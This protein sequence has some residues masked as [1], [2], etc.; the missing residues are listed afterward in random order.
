[1]KIQCD[2]CEK[3]EAS[4]F[5]SAD[6]ASLCYA[7]DYTI[8]HANKLASKHKRFSLHKPTSKYTPLCDICQERRAYIFCREDRAIFCTEC[9]LPIH[10]ANENT[11][12]HNRFLLTGVKVGAGCS[13]NPTLLCSNGTATEIELRN[14]CS[15]ANMSSDTGSVSTSSISEYLT[16]TIPGYCMEDLLDAPNGF[17]Y[18]DYEYHI[19]FQDQDLFQ[20]NMCSFPFA[21]CSPQ[22]QV[23]SS[24][25]STWNVPQ[26]DYLVGVKELPKAQAVEGYYNGY[27]LPSVTPPLIKKSKRSR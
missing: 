17:F 12:K 8:H 19:K 4:V 21:S 7:C 25:L 18:K 3:E 16:E 9:D 6:E 24:Q 22:S 26:I 15:K 11:Q 1:M 5:C 2:V 14:S 13:S 10:R 27:T 23:R 20:E